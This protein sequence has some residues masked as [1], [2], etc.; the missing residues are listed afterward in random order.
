MASFIGLNLLHIRT[1][2][3]KRLLDYVLHSL[4][5]PQPCP[6]LPTAQATVAATHKPLDGTF[7]GVIWPKTANAVH[8]KQTD[9][10]IATEMLTCTVQKMIYFLKT[11][12]DRPHSVSDH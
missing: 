6:S 4:I 1:Y 12:G 5:I 7:N 2:S 8:V 11:N 10:A 3:F 9:G